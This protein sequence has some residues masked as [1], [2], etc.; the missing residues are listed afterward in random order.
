VCKLAAAALLALAI[1]APAI[2]PVDLLAAGKPLSQIASVALD[3]TYKPTATET[4]LITTSNAEKVRVVFYR[5]DMFRI[6]MADGGTGGFTEA[7]SD[8]L[9]VKTDYGK[10]AVALEN[11]SGY[12]EFKTTA[13]TLRAYV[14]PFRF[15]LYKADG[16]LI[17]Q[18]YQPISY[19]SSSGSSQYMATDESE[20]FYGGGMQVGNVSHK[21]T[22]I[23]ITGRKNG[24]TEGS[25]PTSVPFY[26]S[27]KGY[28]IFRNT[29]ANGEYDFT[30]DV[31]TETVHFEQR[32]DAFYFYG[33]SFE[34]ILDRYTELTGRPSLIPRWSISL[35]DAGAYRQQTDTSAR[36]G[37][38]QNSGT[39]DPSTDPYQGYWRG[40]KAT[41]GAADDAKTDYFDKGFPLGWMLPNDGY[42]AEY[43]KDTHPGGN[44]KTLADALMKYNTRL[45]L[46]IGQPSNYT[47]ANYTYGN[48]ALNGFENEI[49]Y[50]VTSGVR[51][52]KIDVAWAGAGS[53]VVAG[54]GSTKGVM[55][56]IFKRMYENIETNSGD[57]GLLISVYGWAGGQRYATIW[58]GDQI[59][60]ADYVRYHIPTFT[61][62]SMSGYPFST[63]DQGSIF[64]DYKDVY[65]RDLQMKTLV[66]MN[67]AMN[68]WGGMATWNDPAG[69]RVGQI[70]TASKRPGTRSTTIDGST[71]VRFTEEEAGISQKYLMLKRQLIPYMYSYARKSYETGA[72]LVRPMVYNYQDDPATYDEKT[73]YQY[74]T[75]DWLLAAPQ[76]DT[77]SYTRD[78]IYLP[79]GRWVDYWDGAEYFGP[80]TISVEAPLDKLPLFVRAG[81]I[82][83][84][85]KE[86]LFDGQET[87]DGT[88]YGEIKLDGTGTA[89][90][91]GTLVLDLYPEGRTEFSLYE[92][93][94]HSV[95]YKTAD[96]YTKTLIT[97]EA[98]AAGIT[99]PLTITV[100]A[101]SGNGFDGRLT[102]RKNLLTI[103][104]FTKPGSVKLNGAGLTE[105]ESKAAVLAAESGGWYFAE[106]EISG[107]L[108]VNTP[109]VST[110]TPNA[111]VVDKYLANAAPEFETA[112]RLPQNLTAAG[113]SQSAIDVS[114]DA[115]DGATVYDLEIDGGELIS[116]QGEAYT[117]GGFEPG[118]SHSF[119][120]RARNDALQA[121]GFTPAVE[122]TTLEAVKSYKIPLTAGNLLWT[123][124]NYGSDELKNAVDGNP[125]TMFH[126]ASAVAGD[127]DFDVYLGGVYV[128]DKVTYLP[129]QDNGGNGNISQYELYTSLDGVTYS[130]VSSGAWAT[131]NNT[132]GMSLK[133]AGFAPV[134]AG[135]VRLRKKASTGNYISIA[136]FSV[137][138]TERDI[139]LNSLTTGKD[140]SSSS[141][142][143]PEDAALSAITGITAAADN[144]ESA[145][146]F[147]PSQAVDGDAATYY[148]TTT[149]AG[150]SLPAEL[151]IYL[152]GTVAVS[153]VTVTP[154]ANTADG[155]V[156]GYAIYVTNANNVRE[157]A[158]GGEWANDGQ[159]KTVN[160]HPVRSKMVHFVITGGPDGVGTIAELQALTN[161]YAYAENE[162]AVSAARFG[163]GAGNSTAA[164]GTT[165]TAITD[166]DTSTF[167]ETSYSSGN[168]NTTHWPGYFTLD[169]GSAKVVT[170]IEYAARSTGVGSILGYVVYYSTDGTN[171]F[172]G[173]S[174]DAPA[175]RSGQFVSLNFDYRGPARYLR[176]SSALSQSATSLPFAAYMSSGASAFAYVTGNHVTASEIK[177]Y[178]DPNAPAVTNPVS[179]IIPVSAVDNE[180]GSDAANVLT[181][182]ITNYW[183]SEYA[184]AITA[185]DKWPVYITIDLGAPKI[186]T[187]ILYTPRSSANGRLRG[188]EVLY[189]ASAS[190]EDF[191]HA[192]YGYGWDN[193]NPQFLEWD[194]DYPVRRVRIQGAVFGSMVGNAALDFTNSPTGT[195][196]GSATGAY[197]Y[198]SGNQLA[199]ARLQFFGMDPSQAADYGPAEPGFAAEYAVDKSV[200]TAWSAAADDGDR[201]LRVDLGEA[202]EIDLAR[203]VFANQIPAGF[204]VEYS[205]DGAAGWTPMLTVTDM[206]ST[207]GALESAFYQIPETNARYVRFRATDAPGGVTLI[208]FDLFGDLPVQ[209]VTLDPAE[210]RIF[211]NDKLTLTASVLPEAA[212]DHTIVWTSS[213]ESV[214][215]VKDGVV[216][217]R[218]A[219]TATITAASAANPSASADCAVT[220]SKRAATGITLSAADRIM[221][222]GE[223]TQLEASVLPADAT[224]KGVTWSSG[225]PGIAEVTSDGFVTAV[226]QGVTAITA[227]SDDD[228]SITA[229]FAVTVCDIESVAADNTAGVLDIYFSE[230]PT[231]VLRM[232]FEI[233][234][235]LD[236]GETAEDVEFINMAR[237]DGAKKISFTF[238]S[239]PAGDEDYPALF[240]VR[241]KTGAARTREIYILAV[242]SEAVIFRNGAGEVITKL[243]DVNADDKLFAEYVYFNDSAARNVSL[244]L[245][246]YRRDGALKSVARDTRT[247]ESMRTQK[248]TVERTLAGR[249]DDDYARAYL[250][251]ADMN[252]LTGAFEIR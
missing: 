30:S 108:Y 138:R 217:A 225:D 62:A 237:D 152:P 107:V 47:S 160:F 214:A 220:V 90:D 48:G 185:A 32:F 65:V 44:L 80:A 51:L 223:M 210:A 20:Y 109:S 27:T 110:G 170:K 64:Y 28:G 209:S 199:I 204:A 29:Y 78:N 50:Q 125:N 198:G 123:G 179:E 139:A 86:S 52:Y 85:Q 218:A 40:E 91:D 49:K 82:V 197:S 112:L 60:N 221:A 97:S 118:S 38:P 70:S 146:G 234:V 1:I 17:W 69:G 94:G 121:S 212:R 21:G 8:M 166:G 213:D 182:V 57:R 98:P 13:L 103:H 228:A 46:W 87:A 56:Q 41:V 137:Y 178:T 132:A 104:T 7:D 154:P 171:W 151:N 95:M 105:L 207:S 119:R 173:G 72:A 68:N 200:E 19:D 153:A 131:G 122:G 2:P 134:M 172:K 102:A 116:V 11:E 180:G 247:V 239:L 58:S 135:Y 219:G 156:T 26:M 129:R 45:G 5:A 155:G 215:A 192:S 232:L 63:S 12:A 189:S 246:V 229:V 33:P 163:Y 34:T 187:Q 238:A 167:S 55:T 83:P 150:Q 188:Y 193:A 241:Y 164:T 190:G 6:W 120:V 205:A 191:V 24:W 227:V 130:L 248:L 202:Y 88:P 76:Y 99:G 158:A 79:A 250:W 54:P 149:N 16:G 43:N 15:E 143:A 245:A 75:G 117:A 39:Q 106:D 25:N 124:G 231:N 4:Y 222:V 67:Y 165:V 144:Y 126:S 81:A 203:V 36:G 230:L 101:A 142:W 61:G 169:L 100:G 10:P 249:V 235:S 161:T 114:W 14:N 211:I 196:G 93:D 201:W 53:G 133:T 174:G 177:V 208:S 175:S 84:M 115:V 226:S 18:E 23:A 176:V 111:I 252:P 157:W 240:S 3:N 89:V 147:M 96:A 59:G 148:K 233:S 195:T 181:D 9:L 136:E 35:G 251:N 162:T 243:D 145:G 42:G 31:N 194:Y 66:P 37:N 73:Q 183:Q 127:A 71:T 184:K 216:T 77:A 244:I 242:P 113:V 159:P 141:V 92:D 168:W 206:P 236:G 22:R 74:M 128:I 186:L 140:A 224:V